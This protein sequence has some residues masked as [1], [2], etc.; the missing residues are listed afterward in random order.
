[1]ALGLQPSRGDWK[2]RHFTTTSTATFVQGSA[3]K[4]NGTTFN[5]SEYSGGETTLLGIAMHSSASSLPAGSVMV[6]IPGDGCFFTADVP[7]GLAGSSLS[8]GVAV[9]LYKS[10]NTTS[11][12]TLSYTSTGGHCAF[13]TGA[14]DSTL[15][16]I[17]CQFYHSAL[18]FNSSASVA[19]P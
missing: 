14:L 10:G 2:Y 18:V 5:L 6:A 16:R 3:V 12:I 9:G 11:T 8:R 1:M 19:Y 17:E 7:T 4:L 15:S 13:I